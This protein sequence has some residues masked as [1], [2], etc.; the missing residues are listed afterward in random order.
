MQVDICSEDK[1][2]PLYEPGEKHDYCTIDEVQEQYKKEVGL[3]NKPSQ[4]TLYE[5]PQDPGA[6]TS[7]FNQVNTKGNERETNLYEVSKLPAS[8]PPNL[9]EKHSAYET[10]VDHGASSNPLY[11][12]ESNNKNPDVELTSSP[13]LP[14]KQSTQKTPL[15][16]KPNDTP[17]PHYRSPGNPYD[18]MLPKKEMSPPYDITPMNAAKKQP[19]VPYENV[20]NANNNSH[21][22]TP[23]SDTDVYEVMHGREHQVDLA[24]NTGMTQC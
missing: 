13:A 17:E 12:K 10:P 14:L 6:S 7:S 22:Q 2:N 9:P 21:Y 20:P 5:T 4:S 11:T 18:T 19:R 8:D 24:E 23:K 16:P 1:N 3:S 15:L